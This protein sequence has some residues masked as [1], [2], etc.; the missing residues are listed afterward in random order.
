MEKHEHT[1]MTPEPVIHH[2]HGGM[3]KLDAFALPISIIIAGLLVSS[4]IFLS[5]NGGTG[6]FAG[7][8]AA[9]DKAPS[10]EAAKGGEVD[11]KIAKD[12]HIFGNKKSDVALFVW[13]D[14]ECPFCKRHHETIQNLLKKYDGKIS[15]VYRHFALDMHPYAKK[16][17][18]SMECA[19][20]VAGE[21]GFV[22]YANKLFETT[23]GNNS[24]KRE[25]LTKIA[26]MVGFDTAKFDACVDS[27]EMAGRVQRDMDT[28]ISAGVQ[29]TPYSIALDKKSGKQIVINGAQP[30][31]MIEASLAEYLK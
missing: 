31:E 1:H 20:K 23:Q 26:A 12:D 2:R 24:L 17:A 18:E 6:S 27:G 16:E 7:A 25:D 14:P 9:A 28:G 10:A 22:K 3:K 5:S 29:G 30:I 19:A 11:L 13:S 4:A 15:I 21:D 8:G